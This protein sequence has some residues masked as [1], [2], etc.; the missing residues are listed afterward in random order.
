[1]SETVDE[2]VA[3]RAKGIR[4]VYHSGTE[5]LEV[6]KGID[7]EVRRGEVLAITGSSGAG[8][9]TLLQILGTLD[10][11]TAGDI[12]ICDTD[13]IL[14]QGDE[15]ADFRNLHIGFIFQFHNLL[16]EF[17][18]LENVLLPT[19]IRSGLGK[20]EARRM[21]EK[22]SDFLH[23]VGLGERLSHRPGQLSGGECQR[24]A[25]VRA[26]IMS[27]QLVLADE[28]SGNLDAGA[29]ELLHDIITEL[30][31]SENQTFLIMTHD[32]TLAA[33]FD[34]SGYLD[35]GTMHLN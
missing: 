32:Q 9:S 15:L 19:M 12:E 35:G 20:T 26:L 16:P 23:R 5:E 1:L 14:L 28:P 33:S 18:A 22:A 8:K 29:S 13:V 17:T 21:E 3:L 7:L 2:G 31:R 27:P 34:R 30:A 4:R 11:P 24:V 10:R 25:V 6:L